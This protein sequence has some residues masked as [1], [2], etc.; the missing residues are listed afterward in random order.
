MDDS[1]PGADS[2]KVLSQ[3]AG[4]HSP[5]ED[6]NLIGKL[7]KVQ[8]IVA[9]SNGNVEQSGH[10]GEIDRRTGRDQN[11][12]GFQD[13]VVLYGLRGA[14]GCRLYSNGVNLS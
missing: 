6:E 10:V 9:G 4:D 7:S 11:L 3:F 8:N 14:G 13:G 5:T 1:Y 12:F 2:D